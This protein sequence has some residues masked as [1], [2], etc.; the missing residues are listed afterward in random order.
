MGEIP[1]GL[2]HSGTIAVLSCFLTLIA[3]VLFGIRMSLS[4]VGLLDALTST[5]ASTTPSDTLKPKTTVRFTSLLCVD[6]TS[7]IPIPLIPPEIE[8]LPTDV[9][10]TILKLAVET[11]PEV[12][13]SE[14]ITPDIVVS[15]ILE[16][17]PDA[18]TLELTA[19]NMVLTDTS[20]IEDDTLTPLFNI[21][22]M[23][24]REIFPILPE[25]FPFDAVDALPEGGVSAIATILP[26]ALPVPADVPV[27]IDKV[28][29]STLQ[30]TE[31]SVMTVPD[32]FDRFTLDRLPDALAPLVDD[33]LPSTAVRY[34]RETLPV[35]EACPVALPFGDDNTTLDIPPDALALPD[36]APVI[37]DREVADTLPLEAA[38]PV[39][40]PVFD[41]REIEGRVEDA[42]ALPVELPV[43][44]VREI[45]A[46]LPPVF[47]PPLAVAAISSNCTLD[48][49][50]DAITPPAVCTASRSDIYYSQ[51]YTY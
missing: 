39:A 7:E 41:V 18:L 4:N 24:E 23:L 49:L 8:Q 45:A 14:L 46:I 36:T 51:E 35:A 32:T 22:V 6:S 15:D 43:I 1:W 25:A 50:P 5:V 31:P 10:L 12:L 34:V 37:V 21:A 19:A 3:D 2:I 29:S 48:T 16:I 9:P 33:A 11:L 38:A 13:T 27:T 30:L 44:N 26:E 40:L 20:S 47:T 17:L 28:T 42:T